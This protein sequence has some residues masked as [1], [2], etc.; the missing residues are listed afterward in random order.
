MNYPDVNQDEEKQ[1][2]F[3]LC[4]HAVAIGDKQN[5]NTLLSNLYKFN[6][7]CEEIWSSVVNYC[8]DKKQIT[9]PQFKLHQAEI[10]VYMSL[11]HYAIKNDLFQNQQRKKG[12]L[13][14]YN[15]QNKQL[16]QWM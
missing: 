6:T 14:W 11:F 1:K 5:Q 9:Y 12:F 4:C 2:A 8:N 15:S 13:H 7:S 10:L 16:Q 3:A